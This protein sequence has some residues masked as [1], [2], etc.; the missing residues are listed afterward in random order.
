MPKTAAAAVVRPISITIV[1][2]LVM[3]VG[4][5]TLGQKIFV[6]ATPELWET[7]RAVFEEINAGSPVQL[8]LEAHLAFSFLASAVYLVAGAFMLA[9]HNWARLMLL[10][11]GPTAIGFGALTSGVS[12]L[13]ILK[14]TVYLVLLYLLTRAPVRAYFRGGASTAP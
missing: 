10:V 5:F 14:A 12:F 4:A 3:V 13:L 11:W 8:P 1:S 6:I 7:F 9:G 2:G